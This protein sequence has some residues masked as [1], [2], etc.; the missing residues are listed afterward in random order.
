[1]ELC[2]SAITYRS[3]YLT[4]LQPGPVLDLVLA[5]TSN[6][7][8]LCFQ[9]SGMC[10]RLTDIIGAEDPLIDDTAAL[11]AQ[12]QALVDALDASPDPV[13]EAV[14]LPERLREIEADVSLLSDRINRRYFA[15]LPTVQP[16]GVVGERDV[17]E[18]APKLRGAA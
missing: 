17:D 7:R 18:E 15:L 16:L 6:P 5:D 9:L 14:R 8:A 11:R 4:V 12:T 3:R 10:T 2:D 1:M 13:G